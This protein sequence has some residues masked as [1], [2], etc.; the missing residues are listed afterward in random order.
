MFCARQDAGATPVEVPEPANDDG[1][2][3]TRP[4]QSMS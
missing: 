4:L 3:R 1:E 2:G